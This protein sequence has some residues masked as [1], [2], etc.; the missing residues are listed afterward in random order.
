MQELGGIDA[1]KPDTFDSL[2]PGARAVVIR[3]QVQVLV[4]VHH[5]T[6]AFPSHDLVKPA[7]RLTGLGV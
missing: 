1:L 2:L 7:L 5:A 3:P 4:R 6:V